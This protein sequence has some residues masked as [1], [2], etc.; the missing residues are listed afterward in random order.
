M[1]ARTTLRSLCLRAALVAAPL[2]LSVGLAT[3]TACKSEPRTLAV[4][5]AIEGMTC[6]SCVQGIEYEVGR[7]E[8]VASVEVDLEAERAKV[9]F[10]EGEI[11]VAAIVTAIETIGYGATVDGEPKAVEAPV[12]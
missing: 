10:R 2:A 7:L 1:F 12:S 11:E 8:G 4:E 3:L 6:E 5:L 9:V